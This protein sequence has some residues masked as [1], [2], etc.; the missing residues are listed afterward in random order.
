MKSLVWRAPGLSARSSFPAASQL[1]PRSIAD[2]PTNVFDA[3]YSKTQRKN[4]NLSSQSYVLPPTL[5]S[6]PTTQINCLKMY[7]TDSKATDSAT[8]S[9]RQQYINRMSFTMPPPSLHSPKS[10]TIPSKSRLPLFLVLFIGVGIALDRW[11]APGRS[12]VS[13]ENDE[14]IKNNLRST[15]GIPTVFDM[16]ARDQF[17]G[18]W[19]LKSYHIDD[20]SA[21]VRHYPLGQDAHGLIV[22]LLFFHACCECASVGGSGGGRP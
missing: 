20:A 22:S 8:P 14:K 3:G 16:P 18:A 5:A 11:M 7:T 4:T 9:G 21:G 2:I 10:A 15:S 19:V 17:V 13:A 6:T 1:P 12:T